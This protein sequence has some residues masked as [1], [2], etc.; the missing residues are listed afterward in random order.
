[1]PDKRRED[2]E[3]VEALELLSDSASD[4]P[5]PARNPPPPAPPA[6]PPISPAPA[7]KPLRSSTEPACESARAPDGTPRYRCLHCG[8]PLAGESELRCSECGHSYDH[9]T[10]EYWFS[11]Q[12]RTRFEHVLWLVLAC[13][14][15]KL[16]VLPQ[17]LWVARL[18][19]A[20]A[21]AWASHL[22]S[23]GKHESVAR[24]YG[25]AGMAIAGLILVCFAWV[26]SSLPFYT[27]DM[28]AGCVLLLAMLHDP[29]SGG[30]GVV[31][32]GRRIAPVLLFAAPIFAIGCALVQAAIG[33][34]L[35]P[36]ATAGPYT[37]FGFV[38]PYLAAAAVWVFVWRTLAGI[39]R[40]L[41]SQ[42]EA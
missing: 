20:A 42:P 17:L 22:A 15:L 16:L 5:A 30:I 1:M 11:G 34:Q 21:I 36:V 2:E 24:Y 7:A 14:F 13:L 40:M 28:I 19:A 33:T 29:V 8:Y 41:F 3:A 4:P 31:T 6:V 35:A 38:V 26:E 27:L 25:I 37:P 32:V 12:E 18:G 39:R 23:R 9:Q 10:L